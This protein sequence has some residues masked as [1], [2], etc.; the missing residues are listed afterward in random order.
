MK[1][2]SGEINALTNFVQRVR[3][4]F[5]F[6]D[7]KKLTILAL[8]LPSC[9]SSL[10]HTTCDDH[11]LKKGCKILMETTIATSTYSQSYHKQEHIEMHL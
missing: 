11:Q 9:F 3:E 5:F 8:V 1:K 2:L 6:K 10:F 7:E 4:G